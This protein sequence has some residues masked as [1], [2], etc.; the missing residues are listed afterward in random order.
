MSSF[1]KKLKVAYHDYVPQSFLSWQ[2]GYSKSILLNDLF[3]GFTVGVITVPLAM[4]VAIGSGVDPERGLYTA[5]IAGFLIS[6]LGGSR[7][8]IGGPTG[9]FIV[10]VYSIVEKHG[11]EGLVIATVMAG[12][13]MILMALA[14][15]GVFLK[16]IPYSVTTGFTLGIALIILTGQVKDFLGLCLPHQPADFIDKWLSYFHTCHTL[17]PW[18]LFIGLSTLGLIFFFRYF[19][20][21]LPGMALILFL[22][23]YG[24]SFF[25]LP[26]ETVYNLFGDIPRT[27]PLPCLPK[28]SFDTLQLLF[29]EAVSIALLG[30][31][32]SLLSAAVAD[33]MTGHR[34][35]S[36]C[37]LLAQ[38]FSNIA[39]VI[40]GGIPA[41]GAIARTAANVKLNAKTPLSGMTAA[42]SVLLLM[43][44]L[45]PLTSQIPLAALAAILIYIAWNMF[46][47]DHV[48][49][50]LKG[51]RTDL[52]VFLWSC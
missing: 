35:R 33:G 18:A 39:S 21:R 5:I 28:V 34:H 30:A 45:G 50:I 3:A 40:F 6:L 41:T 22:I 14:R 17:N 42:I 1:L 15:F 23:S 43:F 19:F 25:H 27:L 16:F 37:E 26:V 52:Y 46:E 24:A 7:V 4:A 11:Y 12:C 29:P 10:L 36:N 44:F 38:G 13:M 31:I 8:Q 2:E 49:A 48:K 20:P 47:F 9:A 51:P 32:E